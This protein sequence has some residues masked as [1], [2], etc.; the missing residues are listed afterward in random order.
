MNLRN[1]ICIVS[2]SLGVGGIERALVVLANY[3]AKA[4]F[5]VVFISCL[6]GKKFYQLNSEVEII[7][8]KF[9]HSG[10]Y[11]SKAIFYPKVIF[12]IRRMVKKSNPD[13]IL[14][15]GDLFSS[16]VLLS[17]LGLNYPVFISDRT[18]PDFKLKRSLVL[19]KKWLYPK[20]KGCIAQTSIAADFK[21]KQFGNRL[22]IR[23]IPN[24]LREIARYPEI[25]R[26][27][28]ILYVG[29]LSWEKGPE[30]LIRAFYNIPDRGDW[31]LHLA[32]TGPLLLNLREL[33]R[34]LGLWNEVSFL[35]SVYNID[36][37]YARASIY[38][39]PSLMEGFP[40]SLCEAMAAGLPCVCFDTIPHEEL[41]THGMDGLV[42]K[43]GDVKA[44][45]NTLKKLM[46]DD[47]LRASL[48]LEA[49]KIQIRLNVEKVG[50]E[51]KDYIF[52]K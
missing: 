45:S 49:Q 44:L 20:A 32:G 47:H 7:E 28:I 12:F 10:N 41:F 16:V 40:N 43:G 22:D 29:R 9:N 11:V 26:E 24:A 46:D 2:P 8:P 48:G 4:D 34:N 17:L 3:F 33:V 35:D 51:V 30:R 27:K 1:T 18:S 23:I 50:Q 37:T 13:N 42:V 38:V 25:K 36:E 19:L 14:V 5:R 39:L 52:G 15:F 31:T 21:R 6:A